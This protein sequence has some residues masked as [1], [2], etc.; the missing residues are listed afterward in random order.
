MTAIISVKLNNP[1]FESQSN[2][3]LNNSEARSAVESLLCEQLT[4][5]L[6][7]N[8][9]AAKTILEKGATASR[10]REA[11]KKARELTRRKTVLDSARLPGK[12]YDC[13]QRDPEK[14]E[15]FI[16]EG[17]SAGG[18]AKNARTTEF[19]A[20]LPLRGKILNVEK[21]R[22]EKVLSNEEIRAMI[23][24]FGAGISDEFEIEKLR[25][26]R[27]ILMTDADVDGAHITTLLL[28]FIYRFMRPLIEGGFIYLAQPPLYRVYKTKAKKEYYV[29][30]DDQLLELY[31]EIGRD[32]ID[33]QRYKGLGEMDKD[34]LWDTTMDP[35][36][37][38]LLR[39]ELSDALRADAIFTKLMG[40]K[41]E[42]R[43]DFINE[44]AKKAAF[45]DV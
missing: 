40:D 32:G 44:Y 4:Y 12:L 11:A 28:T 18:S 5:Y 14:C 21:T 19:Q 42:P 31:K 6:E 45:L 10:A 20:I 1:Q 30:T 39:V 36:K 34:Q 25:Y 35:E 33:I 3:R 2:T 23:T 29:Y 41:V 37:R 43:R 27:I 17:D 38:V 8:P 9:E 16:V 7:T 22:M 26:H 24:A 13:A 15:I